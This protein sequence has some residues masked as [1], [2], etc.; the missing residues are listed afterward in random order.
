MKGKNLWIKKSADYIYT[1]L[2]SIW[3]HNSYFAQ[4]QK[5]TGS[6]GKET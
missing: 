2:T 1:K 6:Q 3:Y 4:K 5:I